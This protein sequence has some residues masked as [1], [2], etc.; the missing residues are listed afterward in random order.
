MVKL[1]QSCTYGV[2]L[3]SWVV[4]FIVPNGFSIL[5][6]VIGL[7]LA[8]ALGLV[9][10][11]KAQNGPNGFRTLVDPKVTP[12]DVLAAESQGRLARARVLSIAET[13]I[14]WEHNPVCRILLLVVPAAGM[15]YETSVDR[16]VRSIEAP[17]LQPECIV[18]VIVDP[19][20]AGRAVI[21]VDTPAAWRARLQ[22][23]D[24][25]RSIPSAPDR[26]P[27]PPQPFEP[28]TKVRGRW[29]V[30]FASAAA[31]AWPLWALPPGWG[32]N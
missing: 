2:M 17:R 31:A 22:A 23:D 1:V 21:V 6:A 32:I 13:G 8:I 3:T 28:R 30:F 5:G 18:L 7:L 26:S 29:L 16:Y 12:E 14:G 25:V 27:A 10:C 15:A 11:S 19:T 24:L 9:V 20:V 4:M